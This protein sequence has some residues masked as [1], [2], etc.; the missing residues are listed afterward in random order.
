MTR[1]HEDS[2]VATQIAESTRWLLHRLMEAES[3]RLEKAA[4][5]LYQKE[6]EVK[7]ENIR[8]ASKSPGITPADNI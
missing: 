7:S 2:Q 6:E 5:E 8:A 3:E 4:R 1:F